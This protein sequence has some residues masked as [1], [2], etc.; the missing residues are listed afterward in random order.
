MYI[1]VLGTCHWKLNVWFEY[2][3]ICAFGIIEGPYTMMSLPPPGP[4]Q[5]LGYILTNVTTGPPSMLNDLHFVIADMKPALPVDTAKPG[6]Y[7]E[8][9]PS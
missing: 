1:R 8:L 2:D 9:R 6:E 5:L 3:L 4:G 7:L